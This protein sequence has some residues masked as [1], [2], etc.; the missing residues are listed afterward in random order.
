MSERSKRILS[1]IINSNLS[2]GELSNMTGIPKSALQRYA[3][4]ET[5]KVPIDRIELIATATCTSP[6]YLMG[7]ESEDELRMINEQLSDMKEHVYDFMSNAF[8]DTTINH[9]Q[10]FD[11]LNRENQNKVII[12][13]NNLLNVQKIEYEQQH[14]EPLA[15]HERTDSEVIEEMKQHDLD[16][17]DDDKNWK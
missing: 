3:T 15:A 1:A 17:M 8:D 14:L 11:A 9:L 10:N 4:G 7:W 6:A 12:Y 16:L 5:E 2:Y 13:T